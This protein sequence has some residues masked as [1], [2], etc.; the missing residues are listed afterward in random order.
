GDEAD[1]ARPE[2]SER[3]RLGVGGR[4]PCPRLLALAPA[5]AGFRYHDYKIRQGCSD[6]ERLVE[7]QCLICA[8]ERE[9]KAM[10]PLLDLLK[11]MKG[12]A[13][14]NG[15]VIDIITFFL[16]SPLTAAHTLTAGKFEESC[17]PHLIATQRLH[18]HLPQ[19]RQRDDDDEQ[20][21]DGR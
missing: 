17:V 2:H 15:V 14:R 20:D 7:G 21:R 11:I 19:P 3:F 5:V 6:A 13:G 9:G 1:G 8:R 12:A 4:A 18:H 16:Q 10:W